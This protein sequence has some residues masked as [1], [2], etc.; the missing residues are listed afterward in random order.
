M[1]MNYSVK[2]NSLATAAWKLWILNQVPRHTP[3]VR[4]VHCIP[5]EWTF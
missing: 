4:F 1:F 3:L 2:H 5:K